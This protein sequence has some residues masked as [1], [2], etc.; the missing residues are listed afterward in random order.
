MAEMMNS[1]QLHHR[2]DDAPGSDFRRLRYLEEREVIVRKNGT[3]NKVLV[4]VG[5]CTITILLGMVA[6]F[7]GR[8]R[9]RV[10]S[11]LARIDA[12]VITTTSQVA[13]HEAQLRVFQARQ[14]RVIDDLTEI[15]KQV[16]DNNDLL[17]KVLIEVKRPR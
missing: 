2:V 8:D 5:G 10:D 4:V 14:E 12:V 17:R 11:D 6:F 16:E 9:V 3:V 13:S 1:K 15:R 7:A